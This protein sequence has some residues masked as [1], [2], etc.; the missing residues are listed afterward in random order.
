MFCI[1]KKLVAPVA[2]LNRAGIWSAAK[3]QSLLLTLTLMLTAFWVSPSAMA[4]EKEM[5]MDPTTGEMVTAPEYG[6]TLTIANRLSTL[7]FDSWFGG[8]PCLYLC[9]V[10]EKLVIGNWEMDRDEFEF[11]KGYVPLSVITGSLAE[12]WEQSDPNTLIFHIRKGVHWHEKPPMNARPL[13]AKDIEYNWHRMLGLGSGFTEASPHQGDLTAMP[14]ESITATEDGTVVFKLKE[15]QPGN[16]LRNILV[17]HAAYVM[18]PEVIE[19]HGDMKDWRNVLGTGSYELTEVVD[20]SSLT[21]TKNP[22]Y[23]GYDEKYLENRLPYIDEFRMLILKED[24]TILAAL[25]SGKL[26]YIGLPGG[27]GAAITSIDQA[28]SLRRTN[29]EIVLI[30]WA[31]RPETAFSFNQTEPPLTTSTCARLCRWLWTSRP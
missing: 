10:S 9:I 28:E 2:G 11:K 22:D 31:Y 18:P 1:M 13:T 19:Q 12:R 15:I 6:G 24:A 5:V 29:P 26:D 14:F 7:W 21:Y 30:P 20:G 16:T 27:T 4:A 3:M 8:G 25:R 17:H 23:W